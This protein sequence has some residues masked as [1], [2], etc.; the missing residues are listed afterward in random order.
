MLV[1]HV[2][3]AACA[4]C[5]VTGFTVGPFVVCRGRGMGGVSVSDLVERPPLEAD[6]TPIGRDWVEYA[7]DL[8]RRLA[9]AEQLHQ[10]DWDKIGEEQAARAAAEQEQALIL[11][12]LGEPCA[13]CGHV[14]WR[15]DDVRIDQ[16]RERLAAAEQEQRLAEEGAGEAL[17]LLVAAEEKVARL[18][19][20]LEAARE[21]VES[22]AIGSRQQAHTLAIIDAVLGFAGSPDA[23][24]LSP[25][26]E[27][28][29]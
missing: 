4:C 29:A 5:G 21:F 26:E 22:Y 15:A 18:T 24:S 7:K 23:P 2:F 28:K 13:E 6:A 12:A 10:Q 9:A 17:R 14:D 3:A 20:A 16:Y 25:I 8:E 19:E 11:A 1:C 27:K